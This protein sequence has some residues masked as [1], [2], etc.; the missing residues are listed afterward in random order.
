MENSKL[1]R[2][3]ELESIFDHATSK[4]CKQGESQGLDAKEEEKKIKQEALAK[5]W[6]LEWPCPQSKNSHGGP[7]SRQ[8]KWTLGLYDYIAAIVEGS[9]V[10][11]VN[12]PQLKYAIDWI[13]KTESVQAHLEE[14]H[15]KKMSSPGEEVVHESEAT[16]ATKE[17]KAKRKNNKIG[18]NNW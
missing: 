12:P 2:L 6:G 5:T 10:E 14:K 15:S 3:K 8:T 11:A 9:A 18:R 17:G 7:T 16:G 1:K 4:K 13:H